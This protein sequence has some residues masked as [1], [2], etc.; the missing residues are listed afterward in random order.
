MTSK[1]IV[2]CPS[3]QVI[4]LAKG[5][6]PAGFETIVAQAGDPIIEEHLGDASYFA[7]YPNVDLGPAFHAKAPKL[8]L[9]QLLSAGFDAVD[10][11]AARA[12]GVPVCNNGGANAISVSE[13][14]LIHI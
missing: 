10:T 9:I 2:A 13:L 5:M 3:A 11:E 6:A 4:E 1:I 8:K 7:C 12:A 14:S